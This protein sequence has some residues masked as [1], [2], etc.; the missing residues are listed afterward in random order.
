MAKEIKAY[1]QRWQ[2][3]NVVKA[4]QNAEAP[5]I[6]IV[7]VHPVGY[8]YEPNYFDQAFESEDILKRYRNLSVVKLEVICRD[9]DLDRLV[10]TI[11]KAACTQS[12]GDGRI[13]VS[14]VIRSVRIRDG[15]EGK[16]A[17]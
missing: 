17:L 3:N 14:D 12:R 10:Q 6:S 9:E 5:G 8:G 7:E 1:I 4:L 2:I 13:F 16:E 15:V 11:Q